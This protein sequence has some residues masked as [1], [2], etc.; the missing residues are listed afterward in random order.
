MNVLALIEKYYPT[1]SRGYEFLVNHSRMVVEKSLSVAARVSHLKPDLE[2]VREAAW[3][4]DIGIFLTNAPAIGC[5]GRLP[6]VCHGY[7]GREILEREG[8][9]RHALVCE[10]HV[11]VGIS[12]TDIVR[13]KLPLPMREMVPV[14]LEEKIVCFADKFFSKDEEY[15]LRECPLET[16]KQRIA[17][18]GPGKLALFEQWLT[19]FNSRA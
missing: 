13:Q 1:G 6:Y 18:Y 19:V 4:H 8:L 17:N 15:L 12:R 14:S 7:L 11:G 9:P 16:V 10:R 2:F 3:F 5:R